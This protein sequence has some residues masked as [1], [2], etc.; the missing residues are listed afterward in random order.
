MGHDDNSAVGDNSSGIRGIGRGGEGSK[1]SDNQNDV[2]NNV[3]S[4]VELSTIVSPL[5][6]TNPLKAKV[7]LERLHK[8][9]AET[10]SSARR[11][12]IRK[13]LPNES[14]Q[15]NKNGSA[16]DVGSNG[17][18][19]HQTDTSSETTSDST[20]RIKAQHEALK[21]NDDADNTVYDNEKFP[22]REEFQEKCFMEDKYC[23]NNN[24]RDQKVSVVEKDIMM[25]AFCAEGG[26]TLE[27][28]I[29]R[30][31]DFVQKCITTFHQKPLS[32]RRGKQKNNGRIG[33]ESEQYQDPVEFVRAVVIAVGVT[34][35]PYSHHSSPIMNNLHERMQEMKETIDS[36]F[37]I[38]NSKFTKNKAD[39]QRESLEIMLLSLIVDDESL[40]TNIQFDIDNGNQLD[41][42]TEMIL[43][44][45]SKT[46]SSKP[47]L[48]KKITF[49][50]RRRKRKKEEDEK[51]DRNGIVTDVT[52]STAMIS[53]SATPAEVAR[54]VSDQMQALSL[55]EKG[56]KMRGYDR[57]TGRHNA[58]IS[59]KS[60]ERGVRS[61][62]RIR[63]GTKEKFSSGG[64]LNGF[65]YTP[66][67]ITS[68]T[69]WNS[70]MGSN[71]IDSAWLHSTSSDASVTTTMTATTSSESVATGVSIPTLS[72][73]SRDSSATKKQLRRN[74]V[75][76]ASIANQNSRAWNSTSSFENGGVGGM[77]PVRFRESLQSN[78]DPFAM[79]DVE[80]IVGT[81]NTGVGD[82][83]SL[84]IDVQTRSNGKSSTTAPNSPSTFFSP[85]SDGK[86]KPSPLPGLSS[87]K[88]TYIPGSRKLFTIMALNE[89]LTCAYQ[90]SKLIS[91]DIDGIVQL[92]L[93]SESTAFVPF[94]IHMF[95]KDDHI[96]SVEENVE[97]AN[98]LSHERLKSIDVGWK[99][100][101]SVTMPKA[102]KYY[103]ILKYKCSKNIVAVP[104]R[105]QSKVRTNGKN[106]RVALQ[107]SSNPSNEKKLTELIITMSVP[108][109]VIGESFKTIPEGGIWNAE[110]RHVMWCVKELGRGEKFQLQGQFALAKVDVGK[111]VK[112]SFPIVVRCQ[113]MSAQLSSVKLECGDSSGFPADVSMKFARRFRVSQNE[114]AVLGE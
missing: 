23:F 76:K 101:Y 65:D 32:S 55:S 20:S 112:L 45:Y 19:N 97:Y 53:S 5:A 71:S 38:C 31:W 54:I 7:S 3:E 34:G 93:K 105:V 62:M 64:D 72:G 68:Q 107:I 99:H 91:S 30:E 58:S 41:A 89:D 21:H 77:S 96:E 36:S 47:K 14:K 24:K 17:V 90:G 8:H 33:E 39:S 100:K 22:S 95:D 83:S 88:S 49:A 4:F 74:K 25:G 102:D 37:H 84:A 87:S 86:G 81:P 12:E 114:E 10:S 13:I 56:M 40:K 63:R 46:S 44:N 50:D 11:N 1:K 106:C 79:D 73:P 27:Y 104:L 52:S 42:E 51:K 43:S 70:V 48:F 60:S 80:N 59:A 18:Q 110:K 92:Q 108:D 2:F 66:I 109:T 103:P 111:D 28:I 113:S 94:T 9:L 15:G 57:K 29:V 78:F 6:T 82:L 85:P 98:D 69:S 75:M 26:L 67:S 61:P 35:A 16:S